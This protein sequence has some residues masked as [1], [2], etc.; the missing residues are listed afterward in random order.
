MSKER[1]QEELSKEE[2]GSEIKD[3]MNPQIENLDEPEDSTISLT[4]K[5]KSVTILGNLLDDMTEYAHKAMP[6]EAI[7]LLGGTEFRPSEL[8]V[9]KILFVT[10]GDEVSVS[11]SDEDFNSF[12]EILEGDLYCCGWWHSHPGYGLFLSQTDIT[13]QIYSF[14]LHNDISVALVV[15][16]TSIGANGRAAFQFYQVV[17]EE[18]KTP[19]TYKE[20]ASYIQ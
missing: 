1:K 2:T 4:S 20:I 19:F 7:G 8:K 3:N 6:R 9:S 5:V 10:E 13:T 18:G 16:P 14:Q 15:E 12:Q 17:G 11:F